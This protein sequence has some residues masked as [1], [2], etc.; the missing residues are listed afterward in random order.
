VPVQHM[1]NAILKTC[2]GSAT[3]DGRP[4]DL[5]L[6]QSRVTTSADGGDGAGQWV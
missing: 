3:V 6:Q 4:R 5:Y 1:S 2:G